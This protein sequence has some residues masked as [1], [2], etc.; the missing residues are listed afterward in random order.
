MGP[1]AAVPGSAAGLLGPGGSQRCSSLLAPARGA[2]ARRTP[3]SLSGWIKEGHGRGK[4][5]AASSRPGRG[6]AAALKDGKQG[7]G[8]AVGSPPPCT[9]R[10]R[11]PGVGMSISLSRGGRGRAAGTAQPS[12]RAGRWGAR[13]PRAA[14]GRAVRCGRRCPGSGGGG[15]CFPRRAEEEEEISG[16]LMRGCSSAERWDYTARRQSCGLCVRAGL[17]VS[18]RL[19]ANRTFSAVKKKPRRCGRA[20]RCLCDCDMKRWRSLPSPSLPLGLHF[21]PN[22]FCLPVSLKPSFLPSFPPSHP[23]GYHRLPSRSAE[24]PRLRDLA[25]PV[26][27]AFWSS[28]ET[29]HL[30]Q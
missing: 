12:G 14:S 19:P 23:A 6:V 30:H 28:K 13:G 2:P 15:R 29:G 24:T 3:P 5:R 26:G 8:G 27:S 9:P 17:V 11:P 4:R 16:F 22:S 21:L 1:W 7:R 25:E 18:A 20:Q 10:G